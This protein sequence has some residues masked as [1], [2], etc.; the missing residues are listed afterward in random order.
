M[1]GKDSVK[2]KGHKTGVAGVLW[3]AIKKRE[4]KGDL[5][6]IELD[7]FK[8]SRICS[9]GYS[10]SLT[11]VKGVKGQSVLGC[12]TCNTLWQRDVN[13]AKNMSLISSYI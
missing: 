12:S 13:A 4:K 11:K 1:F 10:D 6:V 7:E 8:T 3:R 9:R 2:F 5:I